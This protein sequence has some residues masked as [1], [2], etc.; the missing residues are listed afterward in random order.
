MSSHGAAG[1]GGSW[2]HEAELRRLKLASA[3]ALARL[4]ELKDL[5]TAEHTERVAEWAVR[6]DT[7]PGFGRAAL[8]VLHHH[9]RFDGGGYPVCLRT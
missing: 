1:L 9:E 5:R 7:M 3:T 6:L 2:R 4:I 8:Y